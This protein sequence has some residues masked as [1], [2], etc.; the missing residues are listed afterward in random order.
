MPLYTSFLNESP[1]VQ[2]SRAEVPRA[3]K[4]QSQ[5]VNTSVRL[6]NPENFLLCHAAYIKFLIPLCISNWF[7][8]H[9]WCCTMNGHRIQ[10]LEWEIYRLDLVKL[11]GHMSQSKKRGDRYVPCIRA[12]RGRGP[13]DYIAGI[14]NMSQETG[15]LKR[16]QESWDKMQSMALRLVWSRKQQHKHSLGICYKCI[17]SGPNADSQNQNQN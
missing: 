7:V 9:S 15:E 3:N 6:L 14:I 4:W 11:L 12:I 5:G 16:E 13:L 1:K 2:T 8:F 17:I 10:E